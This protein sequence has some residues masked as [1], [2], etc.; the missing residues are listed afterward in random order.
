MYTFSKIMVTIWIVTVLL[1]NKSLLS[2]VSANITAFFF[3]NF[4][5]EFELASLD[6]E[7]LGFLVAYV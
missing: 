3:F 2:N 4:K 7:D 1:S 5:L 6:S